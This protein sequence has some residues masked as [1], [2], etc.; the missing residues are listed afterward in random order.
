MGLGMMDLW[1]VI[2]KSAKAYAEAKRRTPEQIKAFLDLLWQQYELGKNED[3]PKRRWKYE[4]EN[5]TRFQ[6]DNP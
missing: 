5:Q 2:K 4:Q 1:P 6:G 3:L